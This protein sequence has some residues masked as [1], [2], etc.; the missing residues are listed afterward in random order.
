MHSL[1]HIVLK[2]L[3]QNFNCNITEVFASI[4]IK[5][6]LVGHDTGSIVFEECVKTKTPRNVSAAITAA[7]PLLKHVLYTYRRWCSAW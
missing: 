2:V 7:E 5:V 1:S 6:C 3:Q 4:L